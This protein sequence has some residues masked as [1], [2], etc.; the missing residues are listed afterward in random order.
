MKCGQC[1]GVI[2]SAQMKTAVRSTVDGRPSRIE[3]RRCWWVRTKQ[4]G[5][6]KLRY[7]ESSPTVYEANK[8]NAQDHT[9]EAHERRV[10]AE[11]E[12]MR[13]KI[14]A[15]SVP[16]D[17]TIAELLEGASNTLHLARRQ[18][19]IAEQ[20]ALESVERDESNWRE[21]ESHEF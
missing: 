12:Y 1:R 3:H 10:A 20:Q 15:R 2:T 16:T 5:T 13:L 21:P 18:E 19:A 7:L 11:V 9:A 6:E 14:A 17:A 8:D 4:A